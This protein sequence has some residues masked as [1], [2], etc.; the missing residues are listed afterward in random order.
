MGE[1]AQTVIVESS[2]RVYLVCVPP[3]RGRVQPPSQPQPQSQPKPQSQA[4][5]EEEDARDARPQAA[6]VRL[7]RVHP[8]TGQLLFV[9]QRG[10]DLFVDVDQALDK[11]A[12]ETKVLQPSFCRQFRAVL[13]M[14][15]DPGSAKLLVVDRVELVQL[16]LGGGASHTA[17]VVQHAQWL[18]FELQESGFDTS[19]CNATPV[20]ES[21]LRELPVSGCHFLCHSCDLTKP[22]PYPS[23][24]P[25]WN[26]VASA[27]QS[28]FCWNEGLARPF[29]EAGLAD[30][31]PVLLQGLIN[32]SELTIEASSSPLRWL[33]LS[34][35]LRH[36][37][38]TSLSSCGVDNSGML[39]N[40]VE[41][42][43][44]VWSTSRQAPSLAQPPQSSAS[45]ASPWLSGWHAY[46][47]RVGTAPTS[48]SLD[49]VSQLQGR[50]Q[51]R[52]SRA[53]GKWLTGHG[54]TPGQGADACRRLFQRLLG[55]GFEHVTC[56][57]LAR[58][59]ESIEEASPRG[60]NRRGSASAAAPAA[61]ALSSAQ[62]SGG[63][64]EVVPDPPAATEP[65]G[66]LLH[67]TAA[68]AAPSLGPKPESAEGTGGAGFDRNR[69]WSS[70]ATGTLLPPATR[71]RSWSSAVSIGSTGSNTASDMLLLEDWEHVD[72]PTCLP[73]VLSNTTAT[74]V[75][76]QLEADLAGL[77]YH[78][79][80]RAPIAL[81]RY[82]FSQLRKR[83]GT[84]DAVLGLWNSAIASIENVGVSSG[85]WPEQPTPSPSPSTP[86]QDGQGASEQRDTQVN[87]EAR[88]QTG[89]ML[90]VCED[91][92][93]TSTMASV[94]IVMQVLAEA[95]RA[96]GQSSVGTTA[97]WERFGLRLQPVEQLLG[98]HVLKFLAQFFVDDLKIRSRLYCPG[99]SP[100]VG[101]GSRVQSYMRPVLVPRDVRQNRRSTGDSAASLL[102]QDP[103]SK[104]GN[105]ALLER[106]A[107]CQRGQNL[108]E[109]LRAREQ[110][111]A[112]LPA[113]MTC[114]GATVIDASPLHSMTTS[115]RLVEA[116][117]VLLKP[118][119]ST[120]LFFTTDTTFVCTVML[121]RPCKLSH[122]A[123]VNAPSRP[124]VC[125][126][127]TASVWAGSCLQD[128]RLVLSDATVPSVPAGTRLTFAFRSPSALVHPFSAAEASD[129]KVVKVVLSAPQGRA[130]P[131]A[132]HQMAIGP[133][134][135]FGVPT[136]SK[137]SPQTVL[138]T[139]VASQV[140][141]MAQRLGVASAL[142]AARPA[143]AKD[144]ANGG[145]GA[146]CLSASGT[147]SRRASSDVGLEYTTAV[148]ELAF[149]LRGDWPKAM[150][151]DG[152][153]FLDALRLEL[154]R[155]KLG[156]SAATRDRL[157]HALNVHPA[158]LD[159]NRFVY[160]RQL[161]Q[162]DYSAESIQKHGSQCGGLRD[163]GSACT[164]MLFKDSDN[165]V[166]CM[167][168]RGVF[169][170]DCVCKKRKVIPEYRCRE[171]FPVCKRCADTIA[172][173]CKLLEQLAARRAWSAPE[174]TATVAGASVP[175]GDHNSSDFLPCFLV[176]QPSEFPEASSLFLLPHWAPS[177]CTWLAGPGL[178]S[179]TFKVCFR[180][181]SQVHGLV[182]L[183]ADDTE[184]H[185]RL[186][187]H[188]ESHS[189]STAKPLATFDIDSA[190]T[191]SRHEFGE[192]ADTSV[193]SVTVA[194]KGGELKLR[195]L[196]FV[197]TPLPSQP[198]VTGAGG[199]ALPVD[200]F[201]ARPLT[202][203]PVFFLDTMDGGR[204]VHAVM[205]QATLSS[206]SLT[207]DKQR[208]TGSFAVAAV[209]LWVGYTTTARH[210]VVQQTMAGYFDVPYAQKDHCSSVTLFYHLPSP[211]VGNCAVLEVIPTLNATTC[212]RP[213]K[214]VLYG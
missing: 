85:P 128:L 169:C 123:L 82:N 38:G 28:Q 17:Q 180:V 170:S 152:V 23:W 102:E 177:C 121:D 48:Y 69:S 72:V 156:L 32:T 179:V 210:S 103:M 93:R 192:P 183:G 146:A 132:T 112:D 15:V 19:D 162:H 129:A 99:F 41:F 127:G 120:E 203:L 88:T 97:P 199:E 161:P 174:S 138:Q 83:L 137:G 158:R 104:V 155:V 95:L 111:P 172:S 2:S 207:F 62:S 135:L 33:M 105:S 168:C 141:L 189:G 67:P 79:G 125:T 57:N 46:R 8:R 49:P 56:L 178:G 122:L 18:E 139:L 118:G 117:E 164:I 147:T 145:V 63:T 7:V 142:T 114:S 115:P 89:A 213:P 149:D 154:K 187:V 24:H 22:F 11:I 40:E 194:C 143:Q 84:D 5:A 64:G 20:S 92:L 55:E 30:C 188:V 200:A 197:G 100:A 43:A 106:V 91:G 35:R 144:G 47:W 165:A 193:I 175:Q 42:E 124:D 133:I 25:H 126:P 181:P 163:N 205:G 36:S 39:A 196:L 202:H 54:Q 77:R 101:L 109:R 150:H 87:V 58:G 173:Q 131:E 3:A 208:S 96:T 191:A 61:S 31:C 44:A 80:A 107:K 94:F 34:R 74:P 157:L 186:T 98:P 26:P 6:N 71:G 53:Q 13:G 153:C 184:Q 16:S 113:S 78:F 68:G 29:D 75:A 185:Q 81:L 59:E 212:P 110:Q 76:P 12:A 136:D 90:L 206:F 209:R 140:D 37:T 66:R 27:R 1:E 51:C 60:G 167:Y 204:F 176:E 182:I 190:H 73:A 148:R 201:H 160:N 116:S 171:M 214:L 52:L 134:E 86:T 198:D 159:P 211:V 108:W 4:T 166:I 65:T 195:R 9:G 130:R 50:W 21:Y 151:L 70:A 14:V 119:R 10:H 45:P